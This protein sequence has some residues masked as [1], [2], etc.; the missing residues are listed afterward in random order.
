MSFGECHCP[1]ARTA[2]AGG[3]DRTLTLDYPAAIPVGHR[4]DVTELAE[5]FAVA[6][7]DTGIRYLPAG[8]AGAA[9]AANWQGTVR[10]CMIAP[11]GQGAHTT[12]VLGPVEGES[13]AEAAAREVRPAAA[14]AEEAL[15][16]A[17]AA[18]AAAKAEAMRW[19]STPS[20]L[21]PPRP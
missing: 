3:M 18:F 16:G 11:G 12:L 8:A 21:P 2:Y 19:S 4:V 13:A 5:S 17:D 15:G 6:D 1:S 7:L 10:A 20:N 9:G 14:E